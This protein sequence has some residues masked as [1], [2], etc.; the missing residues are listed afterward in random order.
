M[1]K[2]KLAAAMLDRWRRVI[3]NFSV[4]IP[5]NVNI[6]LCLSPC[7][8]YIKLILTKIYLIPLFFISKQD[9]HQSYNFKKSFLSDREPKERI[10]SPVCERKAISHK[11]QSVYSQNW[12]YIIHW[13]WKGAVALFQSNK[14]TL[15]TDWWP[16]WWLINRYIV[17][18]SRA[19]VLCP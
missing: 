2:P 14:P 4:V 5:R 6:L 7:L 1:I 15:G 10:A 12:P 18:F 3:N 13:R 17:R 16:P 9:S 8:F 19:F 11:I